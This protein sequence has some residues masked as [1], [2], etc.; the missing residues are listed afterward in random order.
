MVRELSQGH[1]LY[2][3]QRGLKSR[4][5]DTKA[6]LFPVTPD[7]HRNPLFMNVCAGPQWFP[8]PR[9]AYRSSGASHDA[10]CSGKMQAGRTESQR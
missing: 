2:V 3:I 6:K 8:S 9:A 7:G 4:Q 5:A 10:E 1:K